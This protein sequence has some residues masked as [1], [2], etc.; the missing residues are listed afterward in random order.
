MRRRL[1]A[2]LREI[3]EAKWKEME[4]ADII[5]ALRVEECVAATTDHHSLVPQKSSTPMEYLRTDH[6]HIC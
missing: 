6:I 1:V 2:K 5:A 3:E 4:D